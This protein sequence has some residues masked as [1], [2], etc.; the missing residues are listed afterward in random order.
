MR[1]GEVPYQ[2][3]PVPHAEKTYFVLWFWGLLLCSMHWQTKRIFILQIA[4]SSSTI[5]CSNCCLK[6]Q[7]ALKITMDILDWCLKKTTM[8]VI[9]LCSDL[10]PMWEIQVFAA[11]PWFIWIIWYK[12]L[13]QCDQIEDSLHSWHDLQMLTGAMIW[14]LL[15]FWGSSVKNAM[16]L[17]QDTTTIEEADHVLQAL[18]VI[19]PDSSLEAAATNHFWKLWKRNEGEELSLKQI[20]HNSTPN[21]C[22]ESSCCQSNQRCSKGVNEAE[23]QCEWS[24]FCEAAAF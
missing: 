4:L 17:R 9:H 18:P 20:Q 11:Q 5:P 23:K 22:K 3:K 19:I 1:E 7:E 16:N 21:H 2:L 13:N 15:N 24:A 10:F 14:E 6:N 8:K 12:A